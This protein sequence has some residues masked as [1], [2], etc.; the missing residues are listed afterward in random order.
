MFDSH[1]YGSRSISAN[2]SVQEKRAPTDESVRIL[3]ELEEKAWER[4]LAAIPLRANG[5]KGSVH[6]WR[7]FYSEEHKATIRFMLNDREGEAT[8]DLPRHES[9]FSKPAME[10]IAEAIQKEIARHIAA[11]VLIAEMRRQ[12][13]RRLVE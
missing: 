5:F 12:S 7:D 6:I 1:Y 3:K 8:I 13:G 4:V 10:A 11:E 2:V 9:P